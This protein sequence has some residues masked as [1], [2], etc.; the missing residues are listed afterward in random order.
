MDTNMEDVGKMPEPHQLSTTTLEPLSIPTLDG[1][2]ESLMDCKQ[3]AEQDVQRLC[4]RVRIRSL[5]SETVLTEM[6]AREV[7]QE[8]SNVQPVVSSLSLYTSIM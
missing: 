4:D 3:L 6:Q 8:E 7:L 1:W 5:M 2:V